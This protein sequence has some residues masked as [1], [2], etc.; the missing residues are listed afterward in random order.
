MRRLLVTLLLAWPL[1]AAAQATVQFLSGTLNVQRAD[2]S[3]QLLSEKSEIRVGDVVNTE[4]NSFAQIKFTDGGQMTLRP[5]TRVKLDD[6]AFNDKEPQKDSFAMSLLKGGLRTITGLV[7][8]RGNK[9]AW[10]MQTATATVGIR[11]TDF[12]LIVIPQGGGGGLA[13]GTYVNVTQGAV[14]LV[15]GGSELLVGAGQTGL[16]Q[17]A[18]LPPRLIPQPPNLPQVPSATSSTGSSGGTTTI[19]GSGGH[20]ENCP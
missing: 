19:G 6:Y 11:G 7:G 13:A 3:V 18:A 14:G 15:A 2:G 8:K 5:E 12:V 10:K 4:K 1:A 16:S 20:V 17:S 9:D